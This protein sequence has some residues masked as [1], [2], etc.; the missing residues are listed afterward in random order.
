MRKIVPRPKYSSILS[1]PVRILFKKFQKFSASKAL[2]ANA[3]FCLNKCNSNNTDDILIYDESGQHVHTLHGLRQQAQQKENNSSYYCLSDFIAPLDSAKT[4]YIGSFACTVLGV[5]EVCAEYEKTHDDYN[6][7]MVKAIADRLVEAFA[8]HL[9]ERVRKEFWGYN[10]AESLKTEDLIKLKYDG[11]RPAPGYPSQPDH[12]EK[13]TMWK[14]MDAERECG[15][16]LTESLAM[17]PAASVSG[18]F[19]ANPASVY[20]QVGKV[21][22][23]QV[24]DYGRRKGM[25]KKEVERWLGPNLAYTSS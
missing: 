16:K 10:D 2:T 3:T 4:D 24:E 23:D 11:I 15:V 7:I 17:H 18:L 21:S 8:E 20:F 22:E 19:F 14:M 25:D 5:D 9:H 1:K 6:V 12:T 13:V